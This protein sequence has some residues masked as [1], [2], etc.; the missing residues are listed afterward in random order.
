M[1][2]HS[3]SNCLT[4]PGKS[5]AENGKSQC[6]HLSAHRVTALPDLLMRM[7]GASNHPATLDT[8]KNYASEK[9]PVSKKGS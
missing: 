9:K 3:P 8:G 1:I 6:G 7:A 4:P 2:D 5:P